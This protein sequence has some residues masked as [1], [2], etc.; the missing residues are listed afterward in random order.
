MVHELQNN[1]FFD[2]GPTWRHSRG[3]LSRIDYI[4]IDKP[5]FEHVVECYVDRDIPLSFAQ[6][7]DQFLLVVS[8]TV[9]ARQLLAD[10][11]ASRP[12]AA[13]IDRS[14]TASDEHVA[15]FQQ[16]M[17]PAMVMRP[18]RYSGAPPVVPVGGS[19]ARLLVGPLGRM[20]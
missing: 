12:P 8:F 4:L 20:P 6:K 16:H 15:R 7:D 17:H 13:R 19:G 10:K 1:T 9:P 2:A 18:T 11:E 3:N 14:L 5:L